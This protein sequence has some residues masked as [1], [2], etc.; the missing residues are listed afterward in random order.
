MLFVKLKASFEVQNGLLVVFL[1]LANYAKVEECVD[2]CAVRALNSALVQVSGLIHIAFLFHHAAKPD[3]RLGD[4][5]V[6]V[7]RLFEELLCM[8][9]VL[10]WSLTHEHLTKFTKAVC[11][12]DTLMDSMLHL[13]E[14]RV[15]AASLELRPAEFESQYHTFGVHLQGGLVCS[16]SICILLLLVELDALLK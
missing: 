16:R 3:K 1:L 14:A 2:H 10:L 11:I 15:E 9:K 8:I 5:R 6:L 13:F 4:L 12:I 7:D